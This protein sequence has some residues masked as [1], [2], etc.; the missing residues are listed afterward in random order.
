MNLLV[1]KNSKL[2]NTD[3]RLS[4]SYY[5]RGWTTTCDPFDDELMRNVPVKLAE[6]GVSQ[7]EWTEF[8]QKLKAINATQHS[9]CY[10]I[11][12]GILC[13][14]F[15]MMLPC[16]CCPILRRDMMAF[17]TQLREWQSEFNTR[18]LEPKGIF[19]KTQSICFAY[20]ESKPD[21]STE[22]RRFTERWISFALSAQEAALLREEPHVTGDIES[23]SCLGG[24][25]EQELCMHQD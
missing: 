24:V 25:N 20:H 10:E 15:Y 5:I 23:W 14:P 6:K 11:S 16:I 22:K 19:C 3:E 9:A 13:L 2:K 1:D 12:C 8:V 7:G 4:I 17:D 21:G 18:V